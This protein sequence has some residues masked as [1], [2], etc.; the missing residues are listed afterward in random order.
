[1]SNNFAIYTPSPHFGSVKNPF[2]KD[3]ANVGLFKALVQHG[4]FDELTVLSVIPGNEEEVSHALLRGPMDRT[5]IRT[6]SIY[7]AHAAIRSGC[8]LRGKADLAD[9]AW[10]RRYVGDRR[11]SLIGLI[12]TIGAPAIRDYMAASTIAPLQPWDALIC[13]SPSV[14]DA[15]R[16]MFDAFTDYV[17]DRFGGSKR[18]Q[19]DLPL[20]PLGVDGQAIADQADRPDRR[21]EWRSRLNVG[22]DDVL[23]L[24]LGRLSFFEKAFPQPMFK[25]IAKAAVLAGKRLHFAMVGWFPNEPI[26][27]ELYEE[28][29]R[30]YA[31]DV[32]V[33][34]LDGNNPEVVAG[35]WSA[36][37]IFLSLVDN[38]QETFG[39]APL[40]AMAAGLPVVASDWDGYRYTVR[41]GIEGFL[42][43]TLGGPSGFPGRMMS[44]RHVFGQ[45]AYQYYVGSVA[46]H[47]AVDIDQAAERIGRLAVDAQLRR[48]MGMAG[49]DRIRIS[50]DWPVIARQISQL[51]ADLGRKRV[52]ERG[53]GRSDL[54]PENPIKGDP[55]AQLGGFATSV[56]S[57]ETR[58]SLPAGMTSAALQDGLLRTRD[59]RLDSFA[60]NWRMDLA[61]CK[62]LL[63]CIGREPVSLQQLLSQLEP[64]RRE[65][66]AMA[67]VWMCKLGLIAWD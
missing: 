35:L 34:F 31:P 23:V 63:D 42:V 52:E 11:Y 4:G 13:T 53:F 30:A 65:V 3:T 37:D 1:M 25:A 67:L 18:P 5:R 17:S 38:I 40:E 16:N 58:L 12:H 60:D 21:E 9:Q 43:R 27:P 47:T 36:S 8:I 57:P 19:P 55:Y 28:A 48:S 29:A 6:G 44:L 50:F 22:Q 41:D 14:Q 61:G 45:D 15:M 2:G 62:S 51:N 46:Q 49:R 59:V 33:H 20:V 10:L 24:W 39:L 32:P 7:D 26:G 56:L 54:W 66:A 64:H